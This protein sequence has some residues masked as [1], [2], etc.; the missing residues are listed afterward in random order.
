MTAQPLPDAAEAI[1]AAL[2]CGRQGCAC[3]RGP[4]VHCPNHDDRD[5]SFTVH[6]AA[7]GRPLVNCKSGCAQAAVV[8]ALRERGV[9]PERG[10]TTATAAQSGPL[11][12]EKLTAIY[13]YVT[14]DGELVGEKGRWDRPD[15]KKRFAWRRPGLTHWPRES[16]IRVAEMPL[17][18]VELLAADPDAPVVVVEG[19]KAAQAC[20]AQGLLA[21]CFGGG[22]GATDFGA[23]WE[24]LRG[25]DVI[26]WPDN[27]EQGRRYM[28]R[29]MAALKGVASSLT[30]VQ[31]PLPEKGDAVE[32][33]AAGGTVL[34]LLDH[35][36]PTG[37]VVDYLA[38]D[39]VRVRVPTAMGV[40]ALTFTEMEKT[41]RALDAEVEVRLEGPGQ[42]G[43][44]YS[45]RLNL[46]SASQ[47]T[48][49]R[50]DLDA[51]YGKEIGWTAVLNTALTLARS[52]YVNQERAVAVREIVDTE[53]APEV[54]ATLLPAGVPTVV[55]GHGSA[56]KTYLVL[57]LCVG[58]ALGQPVCGLAVQR[59]AVLYIDYEDTDTNWKRR[60]RRIT[61]GLGYEELPDLAL[62]YWPARGIPLPDQIDAIRQTVER[63]GITLVVVDAAADACGGEPEKA[64]VALRY[65]NALDKLGPG[66]TTL[67]IAHVAGANT[68]DSERPFGS[69][70]WHNRARRTWFVR[71]VQEEE[72]DVID[73]GLYCKKVN[74]GRKP[75]PLG[76][77][78]AFEGRSGPVRIEQASLTDTPEL[79]RTRSLKDL[80]WDLLRRPMT[81][82]DLTTL[83]AD[84]TGRSFQ[85]ERERQK[86]QESVAAILRQYQNLFARQEGETVAGG[87]GKPATW[88]RLQPEKPEQNPN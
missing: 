21:V 20:R 32:Y 27:D 15:G 26:L 69:V 5:P 9:W 83:A 16:G 82:H 31:P 13:R 77:R 58:V 7:D 47:R 6:P 44:A 17:W 28:A 73:V 25:R 45:Q 40:V 61:E 52:A 37:P 75:R 41:A 42:R 23:A 49:M 46:L 4:N 29:V 30:L 87:R 8:A 50:R 19:E 88:A 57:R 81:I 74:D 76:L 70:Y 66:I 54:V 36:P 1:R 60:V 62:H 11:P 67:T 24:A 48:E 85:S 2:R 63:L 68:D 56:G 55:F 53:E 86:F 59:G 33:F 80:L 34:D 64:E 22:A 71:R 38:V 84:V 39:G 51:L 79:A 78:L 35:A 10:E 12:F 65:F 72:S 14:A 3:R 43:D 18:G